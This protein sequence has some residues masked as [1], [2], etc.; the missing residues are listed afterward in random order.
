MTIAVGSEGSAM[1][2]ETFSSPM[3]E[4]RLIRCKL[5]SQGGVVKLHSLGG[6]FEC[7]SW[8]VHRENQLST[9]V[10]TITQGISRSILERKIKTTPKC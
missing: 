5:Y 7:A 2:A 8:F 3:C 9:A 10:K 4:E 6:I 1:M